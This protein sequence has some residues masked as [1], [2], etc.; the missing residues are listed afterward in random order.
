MLSDDLEAYRC[1]AEGALN[2]V[3]SAQGN[4]DR[5]RPQTLGAGHGQCA[6]VVLYPH[7]SSFGPSDSRAHQE[8][9]QEAFN[10]SEKFLILILA[11]REERVGENA[12]GRKTRR[13]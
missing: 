11:L 13:I 2:L 10:L 12:S 4:F 3:H 6:L 7:G 1:F 5:E 9:L 8:V